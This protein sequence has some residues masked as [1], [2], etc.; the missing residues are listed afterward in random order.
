M[1]VMPEKLPLTFQQEWL[2]TLLQRSADWNC[3]LS[4]GFRLKGRVDI[5]VLQ[6]SIAA[7]IRSHGALRTRFLVDHGNAQQ[8]ILE[9]SAAVLECVRVGGT[10][11]L[12]TETRAACIF[13]EFSA[14]Q[15][16][17]SAGPPVKLKL[18][19][20]SEREHWLLL[21]IHRLLV[22]CFSATQVFSHIW[23][24]YTERLQ[25]RLPV[26][27]PA[28]QY[29]DYAVEQRRKN[30]DWT[31]K[32]GGYWQRRL[33]D[34]VPLRWPRMESAT[35]MPRGALGRT[36]RLFGVELSDG[37][38]NLARRTRSL[39]GAV[40]LAVYV[41]VLWHWCRQQDFVLP[42]NVAGRQAEHRAVI[43]FFS[44]ILYLR[45][46][47]SGKESFS[48]LLQRVTKEFY[49]ALSHQDFG[50]QA[51][52]KPELLGGTFTQWVTWHPEPGPGS[53][54]PELTVE[55]LGIRDFAENLTAIPPG[56]VDVEISFFDA[57]DGIHA[58]GVYR[59]DRLTTAAM[60]RFMEDL[61]RA[62]ARCVRD[63]EADV[64]T[65]PQT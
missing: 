49:Q 39:P 54:S 27:S 16:D 53:V 31:E 7:A 62:T 30:Q 58:L 33:A 37:I 50:I 60:E 45:I 41:A 36:S 32:H 23:P 38:R 4:C 61:H 5:P 65:L 57:P 48:E 25:G 46:E 1:S 11:G 52:S 34:A 26:S 40:M 64:T 35:G 2:W 19:Q 55:R 42:F 12:E 6:Q 44:H 22:D 43:G 29:G 63:P 9:T 24:A 15:F 47:L 17:L 59:A 18:L 3:T 10:G 56:M 21:A 13:E 20:L 51:T 28:V 14:L 8:Q